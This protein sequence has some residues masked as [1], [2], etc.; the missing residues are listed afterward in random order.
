M[1]RAFVPWTG[2]KKSRRKSS[3]S[4]EH[5]AFLRLRAFAGCTGTPRA[6]P[7]ASSLRN[8]N[9]HSLLACEISPP[10]DV[11][12]STV[13]IF[14]HFCAFDATGYDG[15]DA[16]TLPAT[17]QVCM[18]IRVYLCIYVCTCV[19]TYVY[20]SRR[21]VLFIAARSNDTHSRCALAS[22]LTIETRP[23]ILECLMNGRFV[24]VLLRV[25]SGRD[26]RYVLLPCGSDSRCIK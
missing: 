14:V 16:F 24:V 22:L 9:T 2:N 19:L 23:G 8:A 20:T 13:N 15:N 12:S 6:V 25:V 11:R 18:H 5:V 10:R 1:Y 4:H 21:R 26:A 17:V 3:R 7:I